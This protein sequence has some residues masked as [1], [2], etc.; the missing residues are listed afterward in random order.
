MNFR[1]LKGLPDNLGQFIKQY[2][3]SGNYNRGSVGVGLFES[4]KTEALCV[5]APTISSRI[6]LN[7]ENPAERS[8]LELS[9][10]V[11]HPD[12]QCSL[13]S[14]ISQTLRQAQ[15]EL[16]CHLFCSYADYT[17][18][19]H[20]GVYQAGSWAFSGIRPIITDGFLINGIFHS[21]RAL[22]AKYGTASMTNLLYLGD[23]Q[24]HRDCGKFFYWRAC[25]KKA[26]RVAVSLGWTSLVYPKPD[27]NP[28]VPVMEYKRTDSIHRPRELNVITGCYR[29]L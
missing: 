14:L 28:W 16:K 29:S 9:R 11:R 26:K 3:Y 13:T 8:I 21:K 5:L 17:Q 19:H 1:F 25:N 12:S 18:T 7:L 24:P 4:D 23:V 2:H 6:G 22:H 20:G 10:L 27:Q 15:V